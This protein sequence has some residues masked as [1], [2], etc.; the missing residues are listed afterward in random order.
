[1]SSFEG[2]LEAFLE[3]FEHMKSVDNE[4]AFFKEFMVG[5]RQPL[6]CMY[7][8]ILVHVQIIFDVTLYPFSS[9]SNE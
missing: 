4:E 7:M 5:A 2:K 6:V 8:Y 3:N 9:C 1:M